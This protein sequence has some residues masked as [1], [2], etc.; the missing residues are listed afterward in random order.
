MGM[1]VKVSVQTLLR[2][3]ICVAAATSLRAFAATEVYCRILSKVSNDGGN[4]G[5]SGKVLGGNPTGQ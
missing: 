5:D 2:K 1:I 3:G 4:I